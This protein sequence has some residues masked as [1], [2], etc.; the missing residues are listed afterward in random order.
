MS[1]SSDGPTYSVSTY[2]VCPSGFDRV[3]DAGKR[4][5]CI[6]VMDTGEGWA[7][8]NGNRSLSVHGEWVFDP[9]N[10]PRERSL[11]QC[12]FSEWAAIR[13]ARDVVDELTVRGMTYD[14][15]VERVRA[16][17]TEKARKALAEAGGDLHRATRSLVSF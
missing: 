12:R 17:A 4:D 13:R 10:R 1:E 15:F 11:P 8:R 6:R 3:D 2:T 14:Q 16:E 5:W 7:I 9:L